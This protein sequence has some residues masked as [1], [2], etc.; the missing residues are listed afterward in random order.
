MNVRFQTYMYGG[1]L[2]KFNI[3]KKPIFELFL[4]WK[5]QIVGFE[6]FTRYS[7]EKFLKSEK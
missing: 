7:H 5:H 3:V 6:L 1:T 2:L 4:I